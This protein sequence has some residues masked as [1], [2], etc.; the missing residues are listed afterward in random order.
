MEGNIPWETGGQ[1]ILWCRAPI[2]LAT[3]WHYNANLPNLPTKMHPHVPMTHVCRMWGRWGMCRVCSWLAV[4]VRQ[5]LGK[6]HRQLRSQLGLGQTP[7][8]TGLFS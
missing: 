2:S 5:F 3:N 1:S 8:Q 6:P 4:D 7:S